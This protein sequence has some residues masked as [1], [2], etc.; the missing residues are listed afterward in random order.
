M[1][2]PRVDLGQESSLRT[3]LDCHLRCHPSVKRATF[4]SGIRPAPVGF[5][6][7]LLD[8]GPTD[9]DLQPCLIDR[10]SSLNSLD[11]IIAADWIIRPGARAPFAGRRC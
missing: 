5:N 10:C 3:L 11:V 9:P 7:W 2:W 8:L 6:P 1:N 4:P